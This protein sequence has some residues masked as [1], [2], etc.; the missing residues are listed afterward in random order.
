MKNIFKLIFVV[1][2]MPVMTSLLYAQEAKTVND[3]D[4]QL[5]LLRDTLSHEYEGPLHEHERIIKRVLPAYYKIRME[6]RRSYYNYDNY[7]EYKSIRDNALVKSYEKRIGSLADD[8]LHKYSKVKRIQHFFG[9]NEY[10]KLPNGFYSYFNSFLTAGEYIA[11]IYIEV[12][13]YWCNIPLYSKEDDKFSIIEN[14]LKDE[15][16][17]NLVSEAYKKGIK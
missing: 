8:Y 3:L 6:G 9:Y 14:K 17:A 15:S 10:Y 5:K 13:I 12:I 2:L 4:M 1:G 7:D 11:D 16:F